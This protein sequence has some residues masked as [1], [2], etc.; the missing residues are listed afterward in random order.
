MPVVKPRV[1]GSVRPMGR[2]QYDYRKA[3]G[4]PSATGGAP[5]QSLGA[6]LAGATGNEI[7]PAVI[8]PETGIPPLAVDPGITSGDTRQIQQ[9]VEQG[10]LRYQRGGTLSNLPMF[11]RSVQDYTLNNQEIVQ[12]T[13]QYLDG[14]QT[15][16]RDILGG[17][18]DDTDQMAR[19]AVAHI[20]RSF[21]PGPL[22]SVPDFIHQSRQGRQIMSLTAFIREAHNAGA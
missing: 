15:Q 20:M 11:N 18:F 9:M 16:G 6:G 14:L 19:W 22:P 12:Q 5:S 10:R 8:A 2:D 21:E 1:V 7:A 3:A 13:K 17:V 4:I